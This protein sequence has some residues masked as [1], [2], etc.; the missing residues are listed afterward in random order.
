M[1]SK[2]YHIHFIG[3]GGIGM[4]GIAEILLNTGYRVSGSDL[5]AT[6]ITRRIQ[7][8][9]G[10]VYQGHR[11]GQITGADVVVTT[12]ALSDDNPE[13][14]AAAA[15]GVPVIE[16]ARMLAE[17]MRP[18][19]GIAVSGAH[20]KTSTTSLVASV[21]MEAGLD[22][23]VVIGGKLNNIGTNAVLGT[24]KFIV[25]E[26]DESDGSFLHYTPAV[27]V[28]TNLDLE[29]LDFYS[30]MDHIQQVFL[31]FLERIPFYGAAIV[32]TDNTAARQL[33]PKINRRVLSY[34]IESSADLSAGS[35]V[36]QGLSSRFEVMYK[37]QPLGPVELNLPGSH[38]VYNS[39]AAIAVG[40]ELDVTFDIIQSALAKTQGVQRRLQVKG[41]MREV[42]VVDDYG[43]HP[44]EIRT[45][46]D[47]V[48]K[49]W[50]N[51]RKVVVF[52]PHRYTRTQ[53]LFDEFAR[54]FD[55]ADLLILL[56]IYAASEPEIKGV[57]SEI[58]CEKIRSTGHA[59]A[60]YMESMEDCVAYLSA[61]LKPNDVLLTQ[62]AGNVL[63]VGEQ[64]LARW[65]AAD[66]VTA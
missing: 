38:N 14:Q 23:T 21:L 5:N 47:A 19:F 26:A 61:R 50:P 41:E 13:L 64:I 3:I 43:H 6:D 37:G 57:S 36:P 56:P 25:V 55:D 30:G 48:A 1:Y 16:R 40:L 60:L 7:R 12:S 52:Q 53:A 34:G 8:L 42:I 28:V 49:G 2:D 17:I 39:L 63:E 51:R 24:G 35:I 4:S 46:L 20:G 44:T 54:S 65:S 33:I 66:G 62:G 18:K 10:T 59:E 11:A 31:D 45:T 22:P 58:L 32:C 9:G 27:A 15:S 29:H